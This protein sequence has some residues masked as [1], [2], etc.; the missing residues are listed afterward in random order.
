MVIIHALVL[1]PLPRSQKFSHFRRFRRLPL[2]FG[3]FTEKSFLGFLHTN[4][5]TL[6]KQKPVDNAGT[7]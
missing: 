2:F 7:K 1:R 4:G 3:F 5:R 6:S